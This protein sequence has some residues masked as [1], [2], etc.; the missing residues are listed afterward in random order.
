MKNKWKKRLIG[1]SDESSLIFPAEVNNLQSV[2]NRFVQSSSVLK[3]MDIRS[4]IDRLLNR[5]LNPNAKLIDSKSESHNLPKRKQKK[6]N[7]HRNNIVIHGI[8]YSPEEAKFISVMNKAYE[9]LSFMEVK[10][11][12]MDAFF[13]E[14]L[15]TGTPSLY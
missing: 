9:I 1:S 4:H 12:P 13:W 10:V 7:H 2:L 3:L 15:Q 5:K 11:K 14:L 6:R 8:T